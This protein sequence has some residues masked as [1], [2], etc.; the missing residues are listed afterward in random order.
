MQKLQCCWDLAENYTIGHKKLGGR[1]SCGRERRCHI[2]KE[3][4]LPLALLLLPPQPLLLTTI[5]SWAVCSSLDLSRK[6]NYL[7]KLLLFR[8]LPTKN[9]ISPFLLRV[10]FEVFIFFF[11]HSTSTSIVLTQAGSTTKMMWASESMCVYVCMYV[12]IMFIYAHV[13]NSPR[14]I[15]RHFSQFYSRVIILNDLSLSLFLSS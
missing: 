14:V 7:A 13:R 6:K 4:A 15:A 10:L 12:C 8:D 1:G 9:L 11:F 2:I 3:T 5:T